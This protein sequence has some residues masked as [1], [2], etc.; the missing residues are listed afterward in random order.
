[1]TE[2]C[3]GIAICTPPEEDKAPEDKEKSPIKIRIALFFD[4]TL[5]NRTNIEANERPEHH[6][7]DT[8]KSRASFENGRT[9]IAIMETHMEDKIPSGYQVYKHLYIPGQGT[10]DLKG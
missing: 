3:E 5:N 4:G 9:N 6:K 8:L 1:M 7:Y 2:M 10:F